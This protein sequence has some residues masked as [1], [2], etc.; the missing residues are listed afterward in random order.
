MGGK[1]KPKICINKNSNNNNYCLIDDG[2]T[3]LELPVDEIDRPNWRCFLL[4]YTFVI[5]RVNTNISSFTRNTVLPYVESCVK[6]CITFSKMKCQN[7]EEINILH[8]CTPYR[9]AYLFVSP[10]RWKDKPNVYYTDRL[11][12]TLG[13]SYLTG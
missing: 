13:A 11:R 9:F 10:Y 2:H 8:R 5:S 3:V 7:V 4:D 1:G 12:I 6:S